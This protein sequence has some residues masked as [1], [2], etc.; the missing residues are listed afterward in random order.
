MVLGSINQ[1]LH[2]GWIF[3]DLAKAFDCMNH[4]LL[5]ATLHFYG[6]LR[7]SED[8]FSSYLTNRRQKVEVISPNT[9]KNIFSDWGKQKY[10]VHQGS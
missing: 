6:I 3:C 8:W 9:T 2:A 1:K 10:G 5:L 7:V 4:E